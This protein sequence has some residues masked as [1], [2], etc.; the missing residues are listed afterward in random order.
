MVYE[1]MGH[2]WYEMSTDDGDTWTIMN[3]GA[4]IDDYGDLSKSPSVTLDYTNTDYFFL[5]Y[6]EV[7]SAIGDNQIVV[8]RISETGAEV[9]TDNVDLVM[10]DNS[11]DLEPVVACNYSNLLIIYRVEENDI[12]YSSLGLNYTFY[13]RTGNPVVYTKQVIGGLVTG[14]SSTSINPALASRQYPSAAS[15]YYLAWKQGSNIKFT[16]IGVVSNSS[17]TFSTIET[18]TSGSGNSNN[19]SPSITANGV[20]VYLAWRGRKKEYVP[21]GISKVSAIGHYVYIN[22]VNYRMR[23]YYGNWGTLNRYGS[24][25]SDPSINS[26][27]SDYM[28]CWSENSGSTNKFVCS[29]NTSVEYFSTNGADLQ[30]GNGPNNSG[31]MQAVSFNKTTLPYNFAPTALL[32]DIGLDKAESLVMKYGREGIVSVDGA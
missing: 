24:G 11:I 4:P 18:P 16:K 3:S 20:Y 31:Q 14:T 26:A 12:P 21:G 2:I 6:Q 10:S 19:Y 9:W 7:Y 29:D 8:K 5:V 28:Y 25:V 22:R 1:S 30:A 15:M 17:L 32:S 27:G 23:D 13:S